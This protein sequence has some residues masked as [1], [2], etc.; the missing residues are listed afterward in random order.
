[1]I[2][3][4][5]RNISW[6][7]PTQPVDFGHGFSKTWAPG[8]EMV[9]ELRDNS[10]KVGER[11]WVLDVCGC[12]WWMIWGMFK[13]AKNGNTQNVESSDR[14]WDFGPMDFG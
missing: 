2:V 9:R 1:M 4:P 6:E 5:L 7:S 13:S 10:L 8:M 12:T 11:D 14:Q 3:L